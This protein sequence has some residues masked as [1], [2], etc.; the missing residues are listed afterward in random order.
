MSEPEGQ[1]EA[2]YNDGQSA[3]TRSVSLSQSGQDFL[4]K[5]QDNGNILARWSLAGVRKARGAP[6]HLLRL[7]HEND[8]ET[9][10]LTVEAKS[11]LARQILDLCTHLYDEDKSMRRMRRAIVGW[12]LAAI[13][14]LVFLVVWGI[15]MLANSLTPFV[16][17]A[18]EQRLGKAIEPHL[19]ALIKNDKK[20]LR[21][22]LAYNGEAR[23]VMEQLVNT[24]LPP[25]Y[26]GLPIS[27][28]LVNITYPNAFALPGGRIL[29][30]EGLLRK[31]DH[32]DEL[33][34]VL[35]HEIAHIVYRDSMRKVLQ[36]SSTAIV[37]GMVVGDFLGSGAIVA[38]SQALLSASYSRTAERR[39]D[40]FALSRLRALQ[41]NPAHLQNLLQRL[42]R[43]SSE[44]THHSLLNY[45]STHPQTSKRGLVETKPSEQPDFQRILSDENWITLK[46]AC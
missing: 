30:F 43:S 1:S 28:E 33:S 38:G 8:H 20:Q 25:D 14:S 21:Y 16:P 4:I 18:Y 45:L 3:I 22:C 29:M 41:S 31:V 23:S 11:A 27:V 35:A 40:D 37:L 13:A 46:N 39:A 24:L 9:A 5:D 10:R 12:S 19:L 42:D 36:T 2:R 32:P 17:Y 7:R 34:A 6:H 44:D 26:D 15:P